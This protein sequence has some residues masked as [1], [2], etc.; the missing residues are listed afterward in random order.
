MTGPGGGDQQALTT[1]LYLSTDPADMNS[2]DNKSRLQFPHCFGCSAKKLPKSSLS[3][4]FESQVI[5]SRQ[6]YT[7]SRRKEDN[8][9][10]RNFSLPSFQPQLVIS[11]DELWRCV[12]GRNEFV[13]V[14][15]SGRLSYLIK[16]FRVGGR[17]K[18]IE[19]NDGQ[20]LN[21]QFLVE[22]HPSETLSD[23][24][25]LTQK[26]GERSNCPIESA[27]DG[28]PHCPFRLVAFVHS[29]K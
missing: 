14:T 1:A 28:H 18:E 13:G 21:Q 3:F 23:L 17:K 8:T 26:L 22:R 12:L 10:A 20:S 11:I 16:G 27:S 24:A 4:E 19:E 25:A 29:H 5:A 7:T 15:R 6:R 2:I 9:K